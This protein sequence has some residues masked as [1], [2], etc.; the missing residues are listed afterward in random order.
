MRLRIALFLCLVLGGFLQKENS[1]AAERDQLTESGRL[2]FVERAQVWT[3]TDIPRMNLRE[4]P[5]GAGAFRPDELVTCDYVAGPRSGTTPKFSCAL[6]DGD[7]VKVRYGAHNHEV[8]GSVLATRLLWALG[9]AADRVYPV[10]VRC[11]GCSSDPWNSRG[12]AAETHDFDQAVIERKPSGH[13]MSQG[14]KR[15]GWAWKEL[16]L[17]DPARGGAPQAHRD[18]LKL[19]AVLIQHTDTRPQ[20]QRLLCLP[21]GLTADGQCDKPFLVLHDVGKTFGHANLF[22]RMGPG[23]VN[24]EAWARTPVWKNQTG[25]AG[26]LSKSFTGTLGDPE[27]SEAGRQFLASLL[28]QLTDQ[29]LH[30]MFEVAGVIRRSPGASAAR[31]ASVEEWVAAFNRKRDEIVSRRCSN[32]STNGP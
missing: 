13:E 20:Q 29:Q 8:V 28:R 7:V 21:G 27:I 9:F 15:A 32:V 2:A 11:R 31:L 17:I 23:S 1:A 6:A 12:L 3:A 16:E 19:L 26:N 18:A 24:F 10:R 22:N 4:G 30:D 25:C 5:G 14:K